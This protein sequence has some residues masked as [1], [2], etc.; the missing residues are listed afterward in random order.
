[1]TRPLHATADGVGETDKAAAH[2]DGGGGG[3]D[4]G[5]VGD[6]D[7]GGGGTSLQAR[8]VVLRRAAHAARLSVGTVLTVESVGV[9]TH[10]DLQ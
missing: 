9:T 10:N 8:G 7:V 2:A 4:V 1:M 5:D 3:G 6:G